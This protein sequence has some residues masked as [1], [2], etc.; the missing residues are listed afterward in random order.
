[1]KWT[2]DQIKD[3]YVLSPMQQG[4]LFHSLLDAQSLT[5]R[6]QITLKLKG[7]V[8]I[9]LLQRAFQALT[10]RHDI[11]RTVFVHDQVNKPMQ[12]VLK[13]RTFPPIVFEDM[14]DW[15]KT[16]QT[17]RIG[18]LK[19]GDLER[20]YVLSDDM[21]MRVTVVRVSAD[22]SLLVWSFHHLI[23][24]G[25]CLGIVLKELLDIYGAMKRGDTVRLEL[26]PR[27]S[28]YIKWLERQNM[29]A[30]RDYW[31][32]YV[33]GFEQLTALPRSKAARDGDGYE[34]REYRFEFSTELT[35][36]LRGLSLRFNV[37]L[38]TLMQT[39]WAVLLHKYTHQEDVMFGAVVSGRPAEVPGIESML[40]LFI[41]TIPVRM[42]IARE[43]PFAELLRK[44]GS[45]EQA[46]A[47][48]QY[49]PLYETQAGSAMKLGMIDH[50]VVF[51]NFPL[52]GAM[53][54]NQAND[55]GL[56]PV[57]VEAFE[58]TNYD[59]N[60]LFVPGER[61]TV[62]F[63]FNARAFEEAFFI[64]LAKHLSGIA[65]KLSGDPDLRLDRLPLLDEEEF[66]QVVHTFNDTA[67]DY[68]QHRLI[69]E[70]FERNAAERP[71]HPAVVTDDAIITYRELN[72]RANRIAHYLR[73]TS[74][75]P[76]SYVGLMLSRSVDMIAAM[77]G[78]AKSGGAYVPMEP[79]TPK[80][81]IERIIDTLGVT[82]LLTEQT[83][84]SLTGA[85]SAACPSLAHVLF[86]DAPGELLQE[87]DIADL[88]AAA[89]ATHTAYVI[90]TSGSTGVPKGV[91]IAHRTVSNLIDWVNRETGMGADDRV[92]FVTSPTFDL[93]VYD[94][95]GM[96]TAG[97]TIRLAGS[98]D[99]RRPERLLRMLREEPITV[100]DSAPAALQQLAPLLL[101]AP[102]PAGG[103]LRLV[104]LSGDWIPLK[105]P[106]LLKEAYPG[107]RVLALGGATEATI[108]SNAFEVGEVQP[109]WA[110]IPYGKPIQNARYYILDPGLQPCPI[111]V[112]GELYIGGDCL[113]VGYDDP[114]LTRARFVPD[115]F[116]TSAA[117]REPDTRT[118]SSGQARMYRT[119]DRARWM[120]DGNIEFLG[121]VDH[122]VKIRGYRVETGEI[123]AQ[124]MKHPAIR[125]ALVID[126]EDKE[127]DKYLCGY[128]VS[129]LELTVRQLR[130][131]L[132]ESLPEYMIPAHF[133]RMKAMP[134]TANGKL[135]RKALPEPDGSIGSGAEYVAPRNELEA[136]LAGIWQEVLQRE[137]GVKDHFIELGGHSIKATMLI[138]RIHKHLH[139]SLPIRAVFQHPT[140]EEMALLIGSA[141]QSKL[142]AIER[143]PRAAAYPVSSAQ[144]RMYILQ[145]LEDSG[146]GYHIPS[147]MTVEGEIDLYRFERAWHGL[148]ERHESLRTS[149]EMV[150]GE[151]M[152][153]IHAQ[154]EFRV[155]YDTLESSQ[156]P[157]RIA[158]FFRPHDLSK[159][160]LMRVA[161]LSTA[162]DRHVLLMDM[163]HII[164]DGESMRIVAD[165]FMK[166]Y[167]GEKPEEPPVQYKDY[168]A[169]Q[170]S[171]LQSEAMRK[172]EAYWLER[173]REHPPVLQ[174][175]TDFPRP[176]E[177]SYAGDSI[178]FELDR[179]LTAALVRLAEQANATLY[180][181][182]LSAYF[183]LLR[184]YSG[185]D[186]IV[187]GTPA[188]GRPHP[189]TA[190]LIGLFVN[191]LAI[192]SG[193]PGGRSFL[194][195][196]KDVRELALSAY[197]HAD[198]P[199]EQLVE[200]SGAKRDLSR[201]PL[202]DTMFALQTDPPALGGGGLLF[203]PYEHK[204]ASA[205]FDITLEGTQQGD[206]LHF[207][208]EYCTDL[209]R[210]SS[211][212]RMASHY[213]SL[214]R[215]IAADP[216]CRIDRLNVLPE[217]EMELILTRF[218]PPPAPYPAD[219]GFLQLFMDQAA[220]CPDRISV[221]YYDRAVTYREL[222]EW[223]GR[224]A[225]LLRSRSVREETVVAIMAERSVDWV[226]AVLAVFK[227]GGAYVPIDPAY[228]PERIEYMLQDSGAVLLLTQRQQAS[229]G[230]AFN[231]EIMYLDGA[232]ALIE[233][234]AAEPPAYNPARLAYVIY[235]SGTTGKPKGVMVEHGSYANVTL[236][237]REAFALDTFPV[238]LLQM[239]SFSF[240]VFLADLARTLANGG[241]LVLC[242]EEAKL[243][244]A[245]LHKLL[246][247]NRITV[248]DM[249]PPL[250]VPFMDYVYENELELGELKLLVIGSD[251]CPA[252]DFGRLLAR[253]GG[254]L[255][256]VNCYGVTEAC[257][258]SSFY[259]AT[260]D[261]YDAAGSV[262]IG[263]PLPNMRM[264]V[265]DGSERP[266]P[267]GVAG[268]L[269]IGGAG[270]ARGYLNRPELTAARFA[271]DPFH[272][273]G[274]IYRTG[275][276]AKW[277]ED[278]NMEFLGRIDDQVKIRGFRIEL[279]ELESAVASHPLVQQAAVVAH[280]EDAE[281]TLC[282][283]IVAPSAD[284]EELRAHLKRLVP[285]YMVPAYF[286]KL[287][288][289]PLTPNGKLDRRALPKP[290]ASQW[291]T[292]GHV[293]PQTGIEAEL[294]AIWSEVLGIGLVGRTDDFFLLG[295][296]SLKAAR[297][298]AIAPNR[299]GVGLPLRTVFQ[300]SVLEH[301]AA[302]AA[303]EAE[304][305]SVNAPTLWNEAGR[306]KLFCFPPLF[307]YG[308]VFKEL[309]ACLNGEISVYAFDFIAEED[310]IAR[311][312]AAIRR[313]QE[314]GP[315]VLLGYSAGG[316]VAV[317][318]AAELER[319]GAEVS[320][321][322]LIDSIHREPGERSQADIDEEIR[323]LLGLAAER[324]GMNDDD[325]FTEER[326]RLIGTYA[327]YVERLTHTC[328]LKAQLHDIRSEHRDLQG[329]AVIPWSRSTSGKTTEYEGAGRHLDMLR[330][331]YADTNAAV[332]KSIVHSLAGA[333]LALSGDRR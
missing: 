279:G 220:V 119:G 221:R 163:H 51:E 228:P 7:S 298:A 146:D 194:D 170:Q 55:A 40:G 141:E 12:I 108:W 300:H 167:A 80:A 114:Q 74:V 217:S 52:D 261:R 292:G 35:A 13:E 120:P 44:A 9:G 42:R 294:A 5:Y 14:A 327:R 47:E 16:V 233:W 260:A 159:A 205:Q 63:L 139:V 289:M 270:I 178:R 222:D 26:A 293:P 67:R 164:A 104:M 32:R 266:Q 192:R 109:D 322:V 242:P 4:M 207:Q 57:D 27:Y 22:E 83:L 253:F 50:I 123:Q 89:I 143:V 145:Q 199:F 3:V 169:W 249:T 182:L 252:D 263:K 287:E 208:I 160:P 250:A 19:R 241:E 68:P 84:D 73:R 302:A 185:Q 166:L 48:Y 112:P 267:V 247:A 38:S 297:L 285:E 325:G 295:G 129:E 268:E 312:A 259:E 43:A 60:V 131:F 231:G 186:D 66:A 150:D 88:P 11:F 309:A 18:Q 117:D 6:E 305:A 45:A 188:G 239:A 56:V 262:P 101:D 201:N 275:D 20:G 226:A 1:M 288:H 106:G 281:K 90:F 132:A 53:G 323:M 28:A 283:Y 171:Y 94:V 258:D 202:F 183:V 296:N 125:E 168:A 15:D 103:S 91:I 328:E 127:G 126:R 99:V 154:T 313:M 2:K 69:H 179:E 211:M 310:R 308:F 230:G 23:L 36:S 137:V 75:E 278:G 234:P 174:L 311:Y 306:S 135:D 195:Y 256:I 321:I 331:P 236:A 86:V 161:L 79:T 198:Y 218:N 151:L 29:S 102:R 214:L 187:V 180:M 191:T 30:A 81:R 284:L 92:L 140:V 248:L 153:R 100:W 193:V 246:L 303:A 301:M 276:M 318:V 96:L 286:M 155:E 330:S 173:F 254:K 70:G 244:P 25:W 72:E 118:T 111:G 243:I 115:P 8:D 215:H 65:A 59:L 61:L 181:L 219:A 98:D 315:Y 333:P 85:L 264:Y 152:Q 274:R 257:I 142:P 41:N 54:A 238:R 128:I 64:R 172:Q 213:E 216:L 265:A 133:V 235:T 209:Y 97:G 62:K 190:S 280:G 320:G 326:E 332:I 147:I 304:P 240:D 175:P 157:S 17:E 204:T 196:V 203:K 156:V 200:R 87:A 271:A 113:A 95:F 124:L 227:A 10:D 223:S 130:E 272:P 282:A 31:L 237:Y 33:Q 212:Q 149:F 299:L 165:S 206:R 76:G 116:L 78:I 58:Q 273:G 316:N 189:D 269:W 49:F 224:L 82:H 93:S 184:Q 136:K 110:S 225:S 317:E 232:E 162:P 176:A 21:L 324:Y 34:Q 77:I 158:A 37:T 210:R 71:D 39:I 24:D 291:R 307:G 46:S 197:E 105:L 144:R 255:R 245:E 148:I 319:S 134:V 277:R 229:K 121:R 107:V 177:R 290:D 329:V 138:S 314:Q 122:Q 251:S